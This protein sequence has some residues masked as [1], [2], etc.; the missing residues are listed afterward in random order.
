MGD[1]PGAW[2]LLR[3][4]QTSSSAS[5]LLSWPLAHRVLEAPVTYLILEAWGQKLGTGTRPLPPSSSSWMPSRSL[6]AH[7]KV[8]LN[9]LA[10]WGPG[11][12]VGKHGG[13]V[14]C[15]PPGKPPY[16]GV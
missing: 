5:R 11:L 2:L 16:S 14:P 4:E 9:I 15:E 13:P 8:F 6:G 1:A 3:G 12:H 7:T 10:L